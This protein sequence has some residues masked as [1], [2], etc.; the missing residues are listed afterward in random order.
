MRNAIFPGVSSVFL[1]TNIPGNRF[2][3]Q[4]L[5]YCR[6][7]FSVSFYKPQLYEYSMRA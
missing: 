6:I 3:K 1:A 4:W 7:D 2:P 5:G